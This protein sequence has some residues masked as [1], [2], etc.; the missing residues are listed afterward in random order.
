MRRAVKPL[1][2]GSQ[3]NIFPEL[4]DE[5]FILVTVSCLK[6]ACKVSVLCALVLGCMAHINT[7]IRTNESIVM[8][9][10]YLSDHFLDLCV[11]G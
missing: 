3:V 11:T 5:K 4:I 8:C 6:S 1:Q 9:G 10:C 7:H 2:N